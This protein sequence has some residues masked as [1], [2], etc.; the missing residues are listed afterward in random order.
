MLKIVS[1]HGNRRVIRTDFFSV[2]MLFAPPP[3][4]TTE[5]PLGMGRDGNYNVNCVT[6]S[7]GDAK[8]PKM[9]TW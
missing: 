2:W 6:I 7:L 4:H 9:L 1:S 5:K 8:L 3:S